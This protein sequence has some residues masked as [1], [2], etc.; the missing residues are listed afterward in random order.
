VGLF[1]KCAENS[2]KW[3]RGVNTVLADTNGSSKMII[4]NIRLGNDKE[5]QVYKTF[6]S[7]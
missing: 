6:T 4:T 1:L 5:C 2:N 7:T 3:Q